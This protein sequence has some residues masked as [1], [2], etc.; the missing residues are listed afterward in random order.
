[1]RAWIE[2]LA[3]DIDPNLLMGLD[4]RDTLALRDAVMNFFL[5]ARALP[6]EKSESTSS[7]ASSFSV[8]DGTRGP[9]KI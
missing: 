3:R 6:T 9:S 4:L 7:P 2:R 8:E 5:E 1:M